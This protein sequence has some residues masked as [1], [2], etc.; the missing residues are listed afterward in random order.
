MSSS[1]A[2]GLRIRQEQQKLKDRVVTITKVK[3]RGLSMLSFGYFD[4]ENERNE[5]PRNVVIQI[6]R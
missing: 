5:L 2:K 1:R 4:P 6:I 3:R